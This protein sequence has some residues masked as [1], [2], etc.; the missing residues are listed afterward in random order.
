MIPTREDL[1]AIAGDL[2]NTYYES[3]LL[4]IIVWSNIWRNS[5]TR[6]G[7]NPTARMDM[8]NR[9]EANTRQ[10]ANMSNSLDGTV[11]YLCQRFH[12]PALGVND[13]QRQ[14]VLHLLTLPNSEHKRIIS[15]LRNQAPVVIAFT[16]AYRDAHKAELEGGKND[17][18]TT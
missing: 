1:H 8:W 18:K 13:A 16:R 11:A 17:D 14:A 10:A 9:L 5:R 7:D 4:L 2:T 6:W 12:I 3:F 15:Q